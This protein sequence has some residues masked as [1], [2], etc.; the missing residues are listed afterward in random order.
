MNMQQADVLVRL[1]VHHAV[2]ACKSATGQSRT[3][4]LF[5]N[6]ADIANEVMQAFREAAAEMRQKKDQTL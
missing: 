2:E 3:I 5:V 6:K 4:N 1:A